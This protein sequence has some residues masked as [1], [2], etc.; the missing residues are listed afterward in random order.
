MEDDDDETD[1]NQKGG[2]SVFEEG[3]DADQEADSDMSDETGRKSSDSKK[4]P[5]QKKRSQFPKQLEHI[6]KGLVVYPRICN[7]LF[8]YCR[9]AMAAELKPE[10]LRGMNLQLTCN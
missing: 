1:G 3:Y 2:G 10:N 9:C 6:L 5:K 8:N 7:I 4:Q